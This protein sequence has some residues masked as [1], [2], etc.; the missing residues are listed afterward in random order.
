MKSLVI[1]CM[2]IL[3]LTL[4]DLNLD[5][6]YWLTNEDSILSP[7]S[8]SCILLCSICRHYYASYVRMETYW[9]ILISNSSEGG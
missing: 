5:N 6:S 4:H 3:Y 7:Y 1:Q 2:C 8:S 9:E